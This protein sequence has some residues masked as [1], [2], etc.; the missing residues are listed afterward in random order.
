MTCPKCGETRLIEPTSGGYFCAVCS[1]FWKMGATHPAFHRTDFA[2]VRMT[3]G[4]KRLVPKEIL[5]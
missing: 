5:T 4:V 3:G 2:T 1:H